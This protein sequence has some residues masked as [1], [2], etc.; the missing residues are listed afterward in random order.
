MFRSVLKHHGKPTT[1]TTTARTTTPATE[2]TGNDKDDDDVD[3][4]RPIEVSLLSDRRTAAREVA[5]W[6][7][8][9]LGFKV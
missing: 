6:G 4:H 1:T 7:F 2:P 3:G 5:V 9:T 8:R